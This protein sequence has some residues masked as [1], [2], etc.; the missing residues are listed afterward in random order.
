MRSTPHRVLSF[1]LLSFFLSLSHLYEHA[2]ALPTTTTSSNNNQTPLLSP[3]H[4]ISPALFADLEEFARI[5]D[6]A[7]CVG[8]AG[9][10]IQKP[11]VC[12]SRCSDFPGFELVTTWHTGVLMGDGCG[13]LVVDHG[14]EGEG[15]DLV[16]EEGRKRGENVNGNEKAERSGKGRIIV[17]FRGTYSIANTIVDL[18]TIPQ[19]YV[20]YPEDPDQDPEIL[21]NPPSTS[22]HPHTS[23]LKDFLPWPFKHKP[24]DP[25]PPA[26]KSTPHKKCTNCTVHS[27]F[28]TSW[29]NTRPY[30]LPHLTLLKHQY[31]N[32]QL[33]LVGHSLGG[34]VAAL[35]ALE[36]HGREW[37]PVVTTFGEPQIGN[38][39]LRDFIDGV[40]GL[41]G[42]GMGMGEERRYRRVTHVD[43]PVP[44]LP[45]QEWGYASHAGEVY[46]GKAELQPGVRDVRLCFGDE[47]EGCIAGGEAKGED[48]FWGVSEEDK[49]RR[50]EEMRRRDEEMQLQN[51]KWE[52]PIPARLKL[53]QLFFAH[54]DYFWRLGLC[55]PGGDPWDWNRP[56]YNIS[57]GGMGEGRGEREEL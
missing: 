32:Y 52:I 12:A 27:G 36:L 11:F 35:A 24:T 10:G 21:N 23:S 39:G 46:I 14:Y 33:H 40:F 6:I 7:Y 30:L 18:S 29:K 8:V 28:L 3:A 13:F 48:G 5:V 49:R 19:E 55:L 26:Q 47:D 51:K 42:R 1:L 25:N 56:R 34:A 54:R 53:W 43:D 17:A 45:L 20:P 22:P 37:S 50:D 41:D 9:T 15:G 44:L 4:T 31:P 38:E 16:E 2:T 57:G